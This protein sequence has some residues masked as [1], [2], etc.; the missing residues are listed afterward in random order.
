MNLRIQVE[1]TVSEQV[2]GRDLVVGQLRIAADASG[3]ALDAARHR[4]GTGTALQCRI[5]TEEPANGFRPDT[6]TISAYRSRAAPDYGSTAAPSTPTRTVARREIAV[7]HIRG[8]AINLP[9]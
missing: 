9:S 1:H 5:N 4:P 6:D 8:M 2:T 7:F 3:T